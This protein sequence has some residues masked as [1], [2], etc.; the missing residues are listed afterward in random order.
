MAQYDIYRNK[1]GPG[2]ALDVQSDQFDDYRTRVVMPLLPPDF[3][4]R[5]IKRLNPEFVVEGEKMTLV[6]HMI[7]SIPARELGVRVGSLRHEDDAIGNA[8]DMLFKG[9]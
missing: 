3:G 4:P 5:A 2:Y 1:N 8:L 6:P 7:A 9:V